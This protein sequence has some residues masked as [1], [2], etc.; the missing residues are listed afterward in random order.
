MSGETRAFAFELP[1][2]GERSLGITWLRPSPE[3]DRHAAIFYLHGGGLLFGTRDD[4]PRRY[5][6]EVLA[7]GF[8]LVAA[9]YPLSPQADVRQVLDVVEGAYRAAMEALPGHRMFLCGRSA[10]A[11]LGLMM[12]RRL[13]LRGT[14][15]AGVMD[16]YGYCDLVGEMRAAL[17]QPSVFY[18]R[19]YA[20]VTP[21]V[22]RR[23]SGTELVCSA[24]LEQ[25]FGL[26]V[27]ARQTGRWG[28]LLGLSPDGLAGLSLDEAAQKA[29]PPLFVAASRDDHDVPFRNSE[30]LAQAARS[31]ATFFVEAGGHDFDRDVTRPE[32]P[33]AWGACL[34]WAEGL[35]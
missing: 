12:A 18:R 14:A 31:A 17:F 26:Y 24:P 6:D 3:A 4:L 16:F 5:V 25:R 2:W 8:T 21:R 1:G 7:R 35:A 13:Q 32:G 28:S 27:Y 33:E 23:L 29:L 15:P 19:S 30:R 10:G 34:D 20:L 22:A 11:Y 9:D